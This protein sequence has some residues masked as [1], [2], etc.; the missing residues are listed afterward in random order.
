M[1]YLVAYDIADDTR[2]SRAAHA[3]LDFGVRVQESVFECLIEDDARVKTLLERL[4]TVI[5]AD[6][7]SVRIVP[8]CASCT[9]KQV[10]IG[11]GEPTRDRDVY[12]V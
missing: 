9:A 1:L 2:R 11:R 5:A 3:L 4:R 7:D 8:V 6:E 12:V 10:I